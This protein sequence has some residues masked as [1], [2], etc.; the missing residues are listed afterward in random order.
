MRL[1]YPSPP[2][3]ARGR[4]VVEAYAEAAVSKIDNVEADLQVLDLSCFQ[5]PVSINHGVERDRNSYVV[6][7]LSAYTTYLDFELERIGRPLV[8]GTLRWMAGRVAKSLRENS[9]DKAVMVNNWLLSTNIYPE[10]WTGEGLDEVTQYLVSRFP[11]HA[12]GFRSLNRFSN[13]KLMQALGASG[14]LPVP[15]RQV[16][17]FDGRRGSASAYLRRNNTKVDASLVSR[18][19]YRVIPAVQCNHLDFDRMAWLYKL[20]YIDKYCDLNPQFTAKWLK[21]G[22][23]QGWL[24]LH[25]LRSPKGEIDGVLGLFGT[26]CLITAPVVGYDTSL[27]QRLGLYRMLTSACLSIAADRGCVLNFSAGAAHF[28]RLRG[29]CGVIEYSMMYVDHLP[30]RRRKAWQRLGS[31][32]RVLGVPLMRGLKL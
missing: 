15:S 9:L 21:L 23:E 16:Y 3:A 7:P 29:G 18:S 27:P 17:L 30:R 14:Y 28:K 22:H 19:G 2:D 32:L 24:E 26:E 1:S 25:L 4:S 12:I 31:V 10:S 6:S 5:F 8:A 11:D 20:L 13:R